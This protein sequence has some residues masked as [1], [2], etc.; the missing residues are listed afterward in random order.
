MN[1]HP[2]PTPAE[3][4]LEPVPGPQRTWMGLRGWLAQTAPPRAPS[5]PPGAS[6]AVS[7]GGKHGSALHG[8]AWDPHGTHPGTCTEVMYTEGLFGFSGL[9]FP[10][11]HY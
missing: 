9:L 5:L 2:P 4:K 8:T 11:S 6:A 3:D 7:T 10:P 1:H